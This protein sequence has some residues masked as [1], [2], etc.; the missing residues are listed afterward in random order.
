M[1]DA[2]QLEVRGVVA[3]RTLYEFHTSDGV[4]VSLHDATLSE[5]TVRPLQ[6]SITL[7]FA[8]PA[9]AGRSATCRRTGASPWRGH[10]DV[11]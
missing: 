3:A 4:H 10:S 11:R 9:P 5:L 8:A 6:Q 1:A 2:G 7:R